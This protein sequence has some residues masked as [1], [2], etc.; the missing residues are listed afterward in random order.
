MKILAVDDDPVFLDILG[1][2]LRNL[3]FQDLTLVLSGQEA[4]DEMEVRGNS[5]DCFL[6][7]IHMP[8]MDGVELCRRIRQ[9]ARY[10][11][12]PIMM[13]TSMSA[14]HFIDDAFAA[15]ATDYLMK[16]L[17]SIELKARMGVIER[18]VYEQMRTNLLE[19]QNNRTAGILELQFDLASPVTI[20]GFE[21]GIEFLALEN[22]L[23]TLGIR[24]SYMSSAFAI[25]I[26]NAGLI[27]SMASPVTFMNMLA[28]VSS[29]L[30]D[31]LKSQQALMSYA[32][33]GIFVVVTSGMAPFDIAAMEREI[34][35][36]IASFENIYVVDRLPLPAASV[37]QM[38][39]STL[40]SRNRANRMLERAIASAL[41]AGG[42]RAAPPQPRQLAS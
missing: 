25:S 35:E 18:L 15:G 9:V 7:D 32:G 23:L 34:N 13:V 41:A 3:G 37:G 29:V 16:P 12:A 19:Q 1:V 20:P 42:T 21:R 40:F 28:D 31:V 14:R 24:E 5:F 33:N 36:G 27:F 10:R 26:R 17:D 11:R 2:A 8:E 22:Y 39:R 38:V 30:E 6:L 4:L